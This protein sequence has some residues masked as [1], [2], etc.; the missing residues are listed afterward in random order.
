VYE[1]AGSGRFLT[2]EQNLLRRALRLA[3]VS[4]PFSEANLGDVGI[5]GA[6][7]SKWLAVLNAS[8]DTVVLKY[9]E[10]S[11][12]VD[13]PDCHLQIIARAS[14][15]LGLATAATS[16]HLREAGYTANDLKF[17]WERQ[18]VER[19]LWETGNLM[20]PH[21]LWADVNEAIEDNDEWWKCAPSPNSLATW[22]RPIRAR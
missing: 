20:D 13:E 14:L 15:L 18:A 3:S 9:A 2:L 16:T 7:M 19:G 1:P 10:Q 4:G 11:S 5:A 21:D 17:W 6:E 12:A 8:S 22:R